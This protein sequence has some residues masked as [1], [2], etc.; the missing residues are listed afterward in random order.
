MTI[1]PLLVDRSFG[2]Q[3]ISIQNVPYVFD[4]DAISGQFTHLND[5]V[6]SSDYDFHAKARYPKNDGGLWVR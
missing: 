1:I 4:Y 3:N 6:Y 5:F 2:Q